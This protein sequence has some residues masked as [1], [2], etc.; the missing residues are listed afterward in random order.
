MRMS[1]R[2]ETAP[3]SVATASRD[4]GRDAILREALTA[5]TAI[6]H[7][8]DRADA[9]AALAP[10]LPKAL[11]P[12]AL[13]VARAISDD[14]HRTT[15]L[16]ALAPYLPETKNQSFGS[17]FT[18]HLS[19]SLLNQ[20][21][22]LWGLSALL[23]SFAGAYYS[24]S[25]QCNAV[26][27]SDYLMAIS[28]LR[29]MQG[30]VQEMDA[31][32]VS[33]IEETNPSSA[34]ISEISDGVRAVLLGTRGFQTPEFRDHRL[35]EV[36]RAFNMAFRRIRPDYALVEDARKATQEELDA[37]YK[38]SVI[39]EPKLDPHIED[40]ITIKSTIEYDW[41]L[42]AHPEFQS[43]RLKLLLETSLPSDKAM[44]AFY[45][46]MF[47][48]SLPQNQCSFPDVIGMMARGVE[49][50]IMVRLLDMSSMH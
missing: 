29:E 7:D 42:V 13:D 50:L 4:D 24:R 21:F 31:I 9:L 45:N 44:L 23:I 6:P 46:H 16:A 12:D 1:A 15:A 3:A 8:A 17:K 43:G 10:H 26:A 40:A 32:L 33:H 38:G 35:S 22:V 49:S 30:R 36:V 37:E 41:L 18:P 19:W 5:A 47:S 14:H 25:S 2:R 39:E 11:L 48:R 27:S 34:I 20:P 28:L